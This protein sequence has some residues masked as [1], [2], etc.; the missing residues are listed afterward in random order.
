MSRRVTRSLSSK[1]IEDSSGAMASGDE[2]QDDGSHN[3]GN[4]PPQEGFGWE[5]EPDEQVS[6]EGP[7]ADNTARGEPKRPDSVEKALNE[8]S[9]ALKSVAVMTG[10]QKE[11]LSCLNQ[12]LQ[13][14]EARTAQDRD[15]KQVTPDRSVVEQ[16]LPPSREYDLYPIATAFKIYKSALEQSRCKKIGDGSFFDGKRTWERLLKD[17]PI[18]K[19]TERRLMPSAFEKDAQ[20]VY[21]EVAGSSFEA[22]AEELWS[23]LEVRLC[24]KAHRS[25]LQDKFF[26]MKW[27]E[28]KESVATYAE[29]HRSASIALPTATKT[30]VLLNRVA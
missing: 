10:E 17:F 5:S 12:R 22:S 30:D 26:N 21:E 16:I 28:R 23:L 8:I 29:R 25:A 27:N 3:F 2:Q 1:Q 24:T 6:V 13:V 4:S 18:E 11:S 14:I 9:K 7:I 15:W 20:R 19:K